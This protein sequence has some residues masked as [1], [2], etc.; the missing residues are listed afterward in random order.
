VAPKALP[1]S[2]ATASARVSWLPYAAFVTLIGV[3]VSTLVVLALWYDQ[4]Q[5]RERARVETQNFT[6]LLE[7]QVG[8]VF[9]KTDIVLR[10]VVSQHAWL[11]AQGRLDAER[12][13]RLLGEQQALLPEVLSLCAADAQGLVRWGTGMAQETPVNVADRDD[14]QRAQRSA[15]PALIVAGPMYARLSQQWVIVLARRLSHPDGS[16]AGVVYAHLATAEFGKAMTLAL[17]PHGAATLR[18]E[19]LALVH[20]VPPP[21]DLVGSRN[22]SPQLRQALQ[23]APEAGGYVAATALDGIER[24]NAYRRLQRYPFYVLVGLATEDYLGEWETNALTLVGLGLVVVLLT[25]MGTW[26][27]YRAAQRQQQ[28][29]AE[30]ER[31]GQAVEALLAERTRLNTELALRVR[32]A[33]AANHAKGRFL[34]AMS[35]E[36]RT[37]LHA[38]LGLAYLLEKGELPAEARDL[39]R[40]LRGAGRS[41]LGIINEVLDDAKIEAGRLELEDAPLQ[42][43]EVLDSVATIMASTAAGKDIELVVHPP[44]PGL[45]ALRGDALRVEQILLNLTGNAIKF[46]ERGQVELLLHAQPLDGQQVELRFRVRDSGIGISPAQQEAIFAP[47]SQAEASISR[48]YGGTGLGLSICR[49]LVRLMGGDM[50]VQSQPGQGS[51]FWFTLRLACD[52]DAVPAA[53]T[54]PGLRA[55]VAMAHPAAREALLECTALLGWTAQG[56]EDG[57]QAVQA[58]SRA[59]ERRFDVAVLDARLP[60]LDG[61]AAARALRRLPARP[62][63]IVLLAPAGAAPALRAELEGE[64]GSAVADAVLAK[65]VTAALLLAAVRRVLCPTDRPP[66]LAPIPAPLQGVRLLVVDDSDTHREVARRVF[67][68]EGAQVVLAEDGPRALQW[69]QAHAGE[70]DVVLL[71][72][73][74][75]GMDGYEMLREV[76]RHA[77]LARLPVVALSAAALGPERDAAM[78]AGM[79]GFIAKPFNVECAVA[80]I[81][82]LVGQPAPQPAVRGEDA[83]TTPPQAQAQAASLPGG[84]GAAA[85]QRAADVAAAA[86][87]DDAADSA[88]E[89]DAVGAIDASSPAPVRPDRATLQAFAAEYAGAVP[90][91]AAAVPATAATLARRLAQAAAGLA[92]QP[93][94]ARA[95]EAELVFRTGLEAQA[96]LLALQEAL[97]AALAPLEADAVGD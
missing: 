6:A 71:D 95:E 31:A 51:E 13:G 37:P 26:L 90:A 86:Q 45:P 88:H 59:G 2:A 21:K 83:A 81:R 30:R 72:V 55:L 38:V 87:A 40:K 14:F 66:G 94:Q 67:G 11:E 20:R 60:G 8:A 77:A 49:R 91:M 89:A 4:Q 10:S 52:A 22:V 9:D 54:T 76:R 62:A 74:M 27:I 33:E 15:A 5:Y 23:A 92:L 85:P 24:S 44:P 82:Q 48:R 41:L 61:V 73:Q 70:V 65:P 42:L 78:A 35:H 80:L 3:L 93:L 32:E 25:G 68:R 53:P 16:F 46:T 56:V 7:R 18:T 84:M 50:G 36:I 96:T 75:P 34:A 47:Y 29:I 12:F 19:D 17:G 57:A 1:R 97:D 63:A 58:V 39:V 69:L 64:P 43:A 79:D 28:A